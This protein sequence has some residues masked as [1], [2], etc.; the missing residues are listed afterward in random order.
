M[1]MI[2]LLRLFKLTRLLRLN[3]VF[4]RFE[5]RITMPYSQRSMIMVGVVGGWVWWVG[6]WV[7]TI[8]YP[9]LHRAPTNLPHLYHPPYVLTLGDGNDCHVCSLD[10]VQLGVGLLYATWYVSV[11]C[12]FSH[13]PPPITPPPPLFFFFLFSF[14]KTMVVGRGWSMLSRIKMVLGYTVIGGHFTW[15]RSTSPL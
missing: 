12:A 1:R 10:G 3:R 8:H 13:P 9:P 5:K 4:Q 11:G 7:G 15:R 14:V 2:R 6:G